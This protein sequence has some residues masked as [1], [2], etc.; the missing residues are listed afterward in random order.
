MM[1]IKNLMSGI[2][3]VIDDAF[4]ENSSAKRTDRIIRL[5]KDI[6]TTWEMPFCKIHEIPSNEICKNLL[7]SASF[8]LLDWKLWPSGAPDFE[9]AGIQA[10][11][12]F[13]EQAKDYFVPVFIFTNEDPEDIKNALLPSG[14]YDDQKPGK[15]FIFIRRK[16]SLTGNKLFTS[17]K[18]W[19][20]GNASVYTLKAWEQAFHEAKKNVFGS[21]YKRS[22]SWPRVFWSSYKEDGAD[23]SFSLVTLINNN[24][25]ARMET[26]IFEKSVLGKRPYRIDG[27]DVRPVLEGAS[28]IPQEKLP[29]NNVKAGDLF[30]KSDSAGNYLLNVRADCDCIPRQGKTIDSVELYCIEGK[31]MNPRQ[32]KGSFLKKYGTFNEQVNQ[33]ILFGIHDGKTIQFNFGKLVPKKFHEVKNKRVGR[34]THPYITR[35]QQRYALYLQRQGLP[36]IPE[37]AIRDA[38]ETN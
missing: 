33:A 1:D 25:L 23:P 38:S 6:E 9:E 22:S 5:V 30:K 3:V 18:K 29:E 15:N 16:N 35:I 27:E 34:I 7:K 21:M 13:L 31:S 17:V 11:I 26:D 10:N 20:N 28:F 19:I 2:A 8:I 14:L 32:V 36:R 37:E 24:L 4:G 12:N